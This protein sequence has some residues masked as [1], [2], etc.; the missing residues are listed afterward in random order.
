MKQILIPISIIPIN[1]ENNENIIQTAYND[2][3]KALK[4]RS[5]D[6]KDKEE[7]IKN[8]YMIRIYSVIAR[9]QFLIDNKEYL[10]KEQISY[11]A[12]Y[13]A[14]YKTNIKNYY[15]IICS[16]FDDMAKELIS[17]SNNNK[18]DEFTTEELMAEI[19]RRNNK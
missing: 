1:D 2:L 5:L 3:I 6:I 7:V 11:L 14:A 18:F 8:K 9:I 13:I 19:E 4:F 10:T 15:K 16:Y 17:K 12:E